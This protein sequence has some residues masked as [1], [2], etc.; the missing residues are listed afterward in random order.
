AGLDSPAMAATPIR[1]GPSSSSVRPS[2]STAAPGGRTLHCFDPAT[3]E[4]LGELP[5]VGADEVR[6]RVARARRAQQAWR[7]TSFERRRQ[8]LEGILE[9]LLDHAEELCRV[10]C[11]DAGK[12]LENALMGEIWPVCEKISHTLQS[13]EKA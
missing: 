9:H 2:V 4:P 6:E 10:V 3:L 12:T 13:G 1:N 8:V 11:R 7:R 5:I